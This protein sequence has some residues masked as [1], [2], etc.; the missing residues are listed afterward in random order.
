MRI[1]G[2][3]LGKVNS[4]L[5]ER[6]ASGKELRNERFA[7]TRE[8]LKEVLAGEKARILVEAGTPARWVAELARSLGHEV[9]VAD[10]NFLPMYVDRNSKRKKTD[11]RDASLLS[12]ALLTGTWRS[13]H[14]R[15]VDEQIR[16]MRLDC[17][18]RH[19]ATRTKLINALKATL[20]QWGV[21]PIKGAPEAL[22]E[23]IRVASAELP[24]ALR[25]VIEIDLGALEHQ[26]TLIERLDREIEV[27]S[28]ADARVKLLQT[29]P[30]VGLTTAA[31]FVATIDNPQRFA[32]GHELGSFL[33]LVPGEH[34]SGEKRLL[35]S[36]T[37][38][39]PRYLRSL[40]VQAA[41]AIWRSTRRAAADALRA[42]A[43]GIEKRRGKRV[44]IVALARKLAG[45]LLAMW[46][47]QTPFNAAP[48][49][50]AA[51]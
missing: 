9:N 43:G 25:E 22:P 31:V 11:K 15:S 46:K 51:A 21:P 38:A 17:R 50:P 42:W 36:I 3:D 47:K 33:G 7:T 4:Q 35:G 1:I 2:I 30:G 23:G 32:S 39:G 20:T 34:S 6:D 45:I 8:R 48:S 18:S 24:P 44:A 12:N 27:T 10:P 49:V 40:L 16:K 26:N 29:A 41:W 19:V 28:G 13:A 37:K 14:L 5:S